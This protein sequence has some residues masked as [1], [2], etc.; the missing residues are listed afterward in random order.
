M[1]LS[2]HTYALP[3]E[4]QIDAYNEMAKANIST[5][6]KQPGAK[7]IRAYRNPFG[8]T[9]Q[10]MV[11]M[12]WDSLASFVTFLESDDWATIASKNAACGLHQLFSATVGRLAFVA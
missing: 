8:T 6:L 9:P 12:E 10:I 1:A 3:P 2:V 11:C 7:E 4:D 5:L